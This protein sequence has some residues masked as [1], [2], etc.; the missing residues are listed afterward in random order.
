MIYQ[1][2]GMTPAGETT[3]RVDLYDVATKSWTRGPDLNGDSMDGFGAAAHAANGAV[4]VTTLTGL[5]QR[6]TP[7]ADAW[8]E[9]GELENARFFHRLLPV[10]G[11]GGAPAFYLLGGGSME[12]GRFT[13]VE[14]LTVAP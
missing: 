12:V 1:I 6:H 13:T 4:Y 9:L 8:E 7:G 3:R 10:P 14:R 2:G 11:E 5:V